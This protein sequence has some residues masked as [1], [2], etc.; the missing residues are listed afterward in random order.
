MAAIV[1]STEGNEFDY[2]SKGNDKSTGVGKS[3]MQAAFMSMNQIKT[4]ASIRGGLA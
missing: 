2:Y 4:H 3:G 1:D